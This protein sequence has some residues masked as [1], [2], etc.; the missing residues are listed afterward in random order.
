MTLIEDKLKELNCELWNSDPEK[1]KCIFIY[2]NT[3]YKTKWVSVYGTEDVKI[4][5]KEA[6]KPETI[7]DLSY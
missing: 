4:L 3:F 6:K 2:N 7:G 1:K 5:I